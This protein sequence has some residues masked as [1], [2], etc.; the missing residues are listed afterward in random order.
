VLPVGQNDFGTTTVGVPVGVP[1]LD[2]DHGSL[3]PGSVI[4]TSQ[5]ANGTA[6]W[7]ASTD[8]AVYTPKPGWSGID[9]FT[10]SV[11]DAYGQVL[12]ESVTITVTPKLDGV[13]SMPLTGSRRHI[14]SRGTPRFPPGRPHGRSPTA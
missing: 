14:W 5:P 6:A 11:L 8:E 10:D 1:I 13:P 3:Q 2:V 4:I 12:S 7:N 9:T